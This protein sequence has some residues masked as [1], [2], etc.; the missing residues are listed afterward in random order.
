M[1]EPVVGGLYDHPKTGGRYHVLAIG[2]HHETGQKL[3][4]YRDV[5]T[6]NCYVREYESW[7]SLTAD[8]GERFVLINGI[9]TND[10]G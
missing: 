10:V 4:T 1:S 9:D 6:D 7:N 8:G 5:V 3:V 2:V